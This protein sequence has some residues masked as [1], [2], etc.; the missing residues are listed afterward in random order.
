MLIKNIIYLFETTVLHYADIN[1][2]Y[3]FS[4][5]IKFENLYT[6]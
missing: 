5:Y 4:K 6:I 3:N 2:I 1:V